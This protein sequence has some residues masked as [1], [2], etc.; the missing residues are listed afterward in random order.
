MSGLYDAFQRRLHVTGTLVTET[1]LHIGAGADSLDPTA[2]DN[3]VVRLPDGRPYIPGSSLKGVLRS[4]MERLQNSPGH[5]LVSPGAPPSECL[6]NESRKDLVKQFKRQRRSERELAEF[7][8]DHLCPVCRLFGSQEFAGR[9]LVAD[10]MPLEDRV[11]LERR[12]GVAIDRDT[13]TAAGSALFDLEVVAPGTRFALS[14]LVEN[15][16]DA[17]VRDLMVVLL[18]LSNG[19]IALGAKTASGLGRVRLVEARVADYGA[20]DVLAAAW[21]GARPSYSLTEYVRLLGLEAEEPRVSRE[22]LQAALAAL[23]PEVTW[24]QAQA[25]LRELFGGE[26]GA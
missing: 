24:Q 3:A 16:S 18:A 10:L 12:H 8:W 22:A 11:L 13:R 20:R 6:H 7:V 25:V 4:F 1:G 2:V 17:Q 21:G 14:I 15:P 5:W 19:E 9:V 23:G 26:R